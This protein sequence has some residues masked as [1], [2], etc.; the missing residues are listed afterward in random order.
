MAQTEATMDSRIIQTARDA[1]RSVYDMLVESVEE[2][3]RTATW[4]T[5]DFSANEMAYQVPVYTGVAGIA[6]FLADYGRAFSDNR[7]IALAE[8]ALEWVESDDNGAAW[9]K[10]EQGPL[11]VTVAV[12]RAGVALG[13]LRL[14]QSSASQ[15]ALEKAVD[16]TALLLTSDPPPKPG[17]LI[18]TAGCGI[19]LLRLWERTGDDRYLDRAREWAEYILTDQWDR[20]DYLGMG[21]GFAGIGHFWLAFHELTKEEVWIELLHRTAA[22]LIEH[23]EPDRGHLNWRRILEEPEITRCQ[24]CHGGAGVGQYFARAYAR[25]EDRR[26]LETAVAAGECTYKYGDDKQQPGQCHGLVGKAELFV[27]LF[28]ITGDRLWHDRASEFI[29]LTLSYRCETQEG[30]RWQSDEPNL[31]SPDFMSGAAGVGHF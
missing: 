3:E 28:R 8:K 22:T 5:V 10:I 17:L 19:L 30:I 23:A 16:R 2:T 15:Q 7:A 20:H 13:W 6:L 21:Q 1:A 27:E 18:G 14:S 24:W 26:Y 31:Y 25:T 29:D 12:G 9:S 11:H 4:K